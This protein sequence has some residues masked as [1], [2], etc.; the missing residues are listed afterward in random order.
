MM[1][2]LNLLRDDGSRVQDGPASDTKVG[3]RLAAFARDDRGVIMIIGVFFTFFWV[4]MIW[5]LFGI[6][7]VITYRE[8]MQ[9]AADTAAFAGAIYNARGM[10]MLALI[11][12]LMGIVLAALLVMKV[13]QIAN[14]VARGSD[15][16]SAE[17][18]C[19]ALLVGAPIC[20][21]TYALATC[22]YDCDKVNDFKDTIK[23]FDQ[24]VHTALY[25]MHTVETL[26][27]KYYGWPSIAMGKS[28]QA[29]G[30]YGN[31]G[32]TGQVSTGTVNSSV[33]STIGTAYSQY[34]NSV[35]KNPSAPSTS[36]SNCPNFSGGGSFDTNDLCPIGPRC[37]LPVTSDRYGTLCQVAIDDFTT[38]GGAL[39]GAAGKIGGL[40]GG[41]LYDIGGEW[42]CDDYSMSGVP[43]VINKLFTVVGTEAISIAAFWECAAVDGIEAIFKGGGGLSDGAASEIPMSGPDIPASCP[44]WSPMAIYS[45]ATMGL[46]Y[47]GVWATAN[48]SFKDVNSNNIQIAALELQGQNPQVGAIATD[49]TLAVARAEFYYDPRGSAGAPSTSDSTTAEFQPAGS[50]NTGRGLGFTI[51][52]N[53]MCNMRWRARL[54]RFHFM[55]GYLGDADYILY[56]VNL[57]GNPSILQLGEALLL[58]GGLTTP[59]VPDVSKYTNAPPEAMFH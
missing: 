6:G 9:N 27:A 16:H 22:L 39:P 15:C 23:S 34:P 18:E 24:G 26:I 57:A 8:N 45:P 46:D 1:S 21:V 48:G 14:L 43:K 54:R 52:Y 58:H 37:G 49:A 29:A 2:I 20:W 33:L 12:N 25:G 47:Y 40:V 38:A 3:N 53:V 10:N 4:G 59:S 35:D 51:A 55:P 42:L 56:G 44:A 31:N 41:A 11:N 36:S 50:S 19:D 32:T 7:T 30:F 28:E 17:E 13:A 5:Y